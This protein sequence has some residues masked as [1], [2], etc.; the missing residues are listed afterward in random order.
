MSALVPIVCNG[1]VAG[2]IYL[3]NVNM[4]DRDTTQSRYELDQFGNQLGV[5]FDLKGR[6]DLLPAGISLT[7]QTQ[8]TNKLR[9]ISGEYSIEDCE[10]MNIWNHGKLRKDRE[11]CWYVGMNLTDDQYIIVYCRLNGAKERRSRISSLLW[12][13]L[14]SYRS[15]S[16]LAG[17]SSVDI[18][19]IF[20]DI[21]ELLKSIPDTNQLE[22][23]ALSFTVF[24]RPNRLA[25][26]GHFGPSRPFVMGQDNRV[27]PRNE[28][29]MT[30]TNGR[31]IR[32]WTVSASMIGSHL[33]ILAHDSSRLESHQTETALKTMRQTMAMT[34]DKTELHRL[35]Q[36]VILQENM[37]RY[38]L[39]A[40]MPEAVDENEVS[41][42]IKR[43]Q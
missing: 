32:F 38:Y 19:E 42:D 17:R 31:D 8:Q 4:Q 37:P 10:W 16:K 40:F 33:Y 28:V 25:I 22:S 34:K 20:D 35:L 23:V 6:D 9:Y 5:M 21:S 36:K 3:E 18:Q 24:D 26:S 7:G 13:H 12:Y 15:S 11:V 29:I 27:S 43:A 14:V 2:I 39:A 1:Q 41:V 30:L